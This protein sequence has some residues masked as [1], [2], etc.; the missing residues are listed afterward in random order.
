MVDLCPVHV[1]EAQK[2]VSEMEELRKLEVAQPDRPN[3][4]TRNKD[5]EE[6]EATF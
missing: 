2:A 1:L 5:G 4:L 6:T 3:L